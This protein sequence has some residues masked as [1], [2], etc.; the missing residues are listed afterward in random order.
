MVQ[1]STERL[2]LS[3]QA[4]AVRAI[5]RTADA[6]G[7]EPDELLRLLR[8][9]PLTRSCVVILIDVG[10][11]GAQGLHRRLSLCH[12]VSRVG[13][14]KIVA[15]LPNADLRTVPEFVA[16]VENAGWDGVTVAENAH[17]PFLPLALAA[18]H[19]SRIE[20]AT[21]VAIAF[22]RSPMMMANNG[23]DLQA[24]SSGRFVLGIGSQV[25]AHNERRFST[26]W[27]APA[28]RMR[29]YVQA[30]R[31]I[32][33]SW[34]TGEPLHY[35]GEHYHFTLMTP[36]FTPPALQT[37][38]PPI[39]ISAV[40]PV[41]LRLGGEVADGV[42]LHPFCTRDYVNNQILPRLEEGMARTGRIREHFEISGGGFVATGATD[43]EVA[44]MVEWVRY[45]IGFYGSTRAYW[46][47]LA[48]HG[49][50]DLG[51]KLNELS[52]RGEWDKMAGEVDDDVVRLFAAVA[53]HDQLTD[54][55][56][57]RFGGVSD[58]VSFT[59]PFLDPDLVEEL[60]TIPTTF[61][62]FDERAP[63]L[64]TN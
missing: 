29:E 28:P 53:R 7:L 21:G 59:K 38:P 55:V 16:G 22:P 24:A 35:E 33:R 4:D 20:L 58:S 14:V 26:P 50:E 6:G 64:G 8:P 34:Q 60:K 57:E 30:V 45:R 12:H 51:Q 52:R 9:D 3:I 62:G 17:N 25:K 15:G 23:W 1:T 40:G 48:E 44:E 11:A 13:R 61:S 37:P 19:S 36:N 2:I 56:R 63:A 27:S 43:E 10:A 39:K 18:V 49:L 31:A 54:A 47:V 46:P 5:V 42:S 32:W 41:M